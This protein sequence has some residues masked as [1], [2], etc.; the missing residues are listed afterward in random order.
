MIARDFGF[1][2]MGLGLGW[3]LTQSWKEHRVGR[4]RS[5]LQRNWERYRK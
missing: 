2:L 1:L 4:Y 3:F 5:R